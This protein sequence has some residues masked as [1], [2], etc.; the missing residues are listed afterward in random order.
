[1][2]HHGIT[3]NG[4]GA[5]AGDLMPA[6][7][8][9]HAGHYSAQQAQRNH[10][11]SLAIAPECTG[12]ELATRAGRQALRGFHR[13]MDLHLH[14]TIHDPGLDFW[15]LN[16]FV[17][18][19]LGLDTTMT[20][21]VNGMSNSMVAGLELAANV[22][23]GQ[24][25]QAALITA[26]DTFH[27]P[28]FDRWQTDPGITYGDAGAAVLLQRD[29]RD[30]AV[31]ELISTAS[32]AQPQLEGLHR[33]NTGWYNGNIYRPPIQLRQRK[34]H[35]LATHD[36]PGSLETLNA[37]AV[38]TVV[39]R[40]LYD[41]ELELDDLRFLLCPHYGAPLTHRHCLAPLG[42]PEERSSAFLARRYGHMGACDHIV[43]L[44]HLLTRR[45]VTAGDHI[46]LLGIG[47]G[48]TWTAAILRITN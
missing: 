41:A 8:A 43:D 30:D 23:K 10:Q 9:I 21:G 5:V 47:V 32:C 33:G 36:G 27:T 7:D 48:M 22:L 12:Q 40:A 4:I 35:W 38:S 18:D 14:S 34:A 16:C 42:F 29:S 15:S 13:H 25:G 45:L 39:K 37:T 11:D 1:M 2:R 28:L 17:A 20:L 46:A 26:G 31:A 44:H 24:P 3:I 6:A 19:Q